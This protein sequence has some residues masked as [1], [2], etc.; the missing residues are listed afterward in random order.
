[1]RFCLTIMLFLFST[2]MN[3]QKMIKWANDSVEIYS[4]DSIV[5][6]TGNEMEAYL[7]TANSTS[8]TEYFI[9]DGYIQSKHYFNAKTIKTEETNYQKGKLHGVYKLWND[10]GILLIDGYYKNGAEDGLW[11]YYYNNGKKQLEGHYNAEATAKVES[12]FKQFTVEK[13][14]EYHVIQSLTGNH[15][16]ADGEWFVYDENGEPLQSFIFDKGTLVGIK[17]N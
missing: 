8:S 5:S 11:I 1:M 2:Q 13:D 7:K 16:P 17:L 10:W 3:A 15:S 9:R 6:Q 12:F 4:F 14:S